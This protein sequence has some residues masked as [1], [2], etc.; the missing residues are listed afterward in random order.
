MKPMLEKLWNGRIAPMESCGANDPE[1]KAIVLLMEQNRTCLE[2][3]LTEEE[4]QILEKYVQCSEEYAYLLTALAFG[5]G[6]S[7]AS[8]L[9]TQA[10]S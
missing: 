7:L 1:V 3:T 6:F 8:K 2:Q 4:K 5:E 10:L 9:L